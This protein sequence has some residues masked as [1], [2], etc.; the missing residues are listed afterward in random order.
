[1][2]INRKRP[3][4]ATHFKEGVCSSVRTRELRLE[5]EENKDRSLRR[6]MSP[7]NREALNEKLSGIEKGLANSQKLSEEEQGRFEELAEKSNANLLP[8]DD[9][10]F[11][12]PN[13]TR[14]E[15]IDEHGRSYTSSHC[16]RVQLSMQDG[17]RT[18][19][20]FIDK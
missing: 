20:I 5:M 6:P 19:K 18:L 9:G 2:N 14:V 8:L 13:T 10:L 16:L 3:V 12:L 15:V 11:R 7:E 4:K 17:S 1:M